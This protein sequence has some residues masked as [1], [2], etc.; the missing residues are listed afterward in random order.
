MYER[1]IT[2]VAHALAQ[3][4]MGQDPL[5]VFDEILTNINLLP[6]EYASDA[7]RIATSM[8]N[9]PLNGDRVS[10]A[11]SLINYEFM[12]TLSR[13]TDGYVTTLADEITEMPDETEKIEIVDLTQNILAFM[14]RISRTTTITQVN[15]RIDK[16]LSTP[17]AYSY[18]RASNIVTPNTLWIIEIPR[19]SVDTNEMKKIAVIPEDEVTYLLELLHRLK[20]S[21]PGVYDSVTHIGIFYP[22]QS[23]SCEISLSAIPNEIIERVQ[24]E[25]RS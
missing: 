11:Y 8:R 4:E 20:I 16:S 19:R 9:M 15:A 3:I 24:G 6:H 1:D 22:V 5:D 2:R 7:Q 17:L 18:M 13:I 23:V 10:E 12:A 21:H 14:R 25:C